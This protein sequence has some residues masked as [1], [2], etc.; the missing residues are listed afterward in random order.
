MWRNAA[1]PHRYPQDKRLIFGANRAQVLVEMARPAALRTK[2]RRN[3]VED[4]FGPL[5]KLESRS[6]RAWINAKYRISSRAVTEAG[7]HCAFASFCGQAA[8]S[9]ARPRR[10]QGDS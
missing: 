5:A 4:T 6:Q 1:I 3:F 10:R 7:L 2:R 9:L 8:Q